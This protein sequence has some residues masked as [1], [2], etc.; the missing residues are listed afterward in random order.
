EQHLG[1][2]DREGRDSPVN[3]LFLEEALNVMM[4][5]GVL[6]VNGRVTVDEAELARMQ[7]PDTIHGLLLARLDRLPPTGRDLLQVASVIGRQFAAEPLQVIAETPTQQAV[8]TLLADLSKTEMTRLIT[9]DP[10]WVYL[11]QHAMTHE[12]AYESLPYA[13]RQLLHAATAAWL[14]NKYQNNLEPLHSVLAYHFSRADDHAQALR[15]AILAADDARDI[16]ANREAID[17]YNLAETHLDALSVAD[18]WETAV[19]LYLSRS[20]VLILLGDLTTAFTDAEN[21][22]ALADSHDDLGSTAVAYNL[23]AEIRYRQGAFDEVQELT[24]KTINDLRDGIDEDQLARAYIWAGWAASSKLDHDL[25]LQ[26]LQKASEICARTNNNYRLALALEAIG[27][28]YYGQRNLESALK[29]MRESVRLSRD[30]STPVNIGFAQNNVAF[31]EFEAGRALD[32]LE[33]FNEAVELGRIT[34]RNL[35]AITLYNQAAVLAYLGEFRTALEN[36]EEALY[37]IDPIQHSRQMI[38]MNLYWGYDYSCV[39]KDWDN[40][41]H[42]F[43]IAKEMI[44]RQPESYPEEQAR[45]M[46]GLGQ[47]ELETGNYAPA[48]DL[49]VQALKLIDQRK[50]RWWAPPTHYYLG[51]L[52]IRVNNLKEATHHLNQ[53]LAK[54]DQSGC[55]DYKPLLLIRL[56]ELETVELNKVEYLQDCIISAKQRSRYADR[57]FC[58]KRS[59]KLL[60]Q[61]A[62]DSISEMGRHCLNEAAQLERQLASQIY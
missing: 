60:S 44:E 55:P 10:E 26:H 47:L 21:A 49:L 62:S 19:Q 35:L 17:L 1:M 45:L 16:F 24:T 56:A 29:A 8:L 54:I 30:F 40:A 51:V 52:Y 34:S 14:E 18:Y 43:M 38:E 50:L 61:I 57:I 9:A 7:V 27:F 46:I 23:M 3:P 15:F 37:L 13:R 36:F 22:L 58:L 42:R 20:N 31:I 6:Q 48:K 41:K 11:F 59:G 2:R 4:G 5:A 12:V 25:G 39:L 33:T 53:G 32:A 28:I